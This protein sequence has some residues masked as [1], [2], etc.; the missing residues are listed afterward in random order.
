MTSHDTA[1]TYGNNGLR[2]VYT[3]KGMDAFTPWKNPA[4]MYS[5]LQ[6]YLGYN[7]ISKLEV[8]S[9]VNLFNLSHY[10]LSYYEPTRTSRYY[11]KIYL[12]LLS[13]TSADWLMDHQNGGNITLSRWPESF[14]AKI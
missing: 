3:S 13:T 1:P 4:N 2:D 7:P 14:G 11:P 9:L 10:S 6:L 8:V 5:E 12:G